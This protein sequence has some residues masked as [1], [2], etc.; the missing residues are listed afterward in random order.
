MEKSNAKKST[1]PALS[2]MQ[3]T[4]IGVMT[5]V[6]CILAPLVIPLPISPVPISFTNLAVYISLYVLGMKAGTISYL[7]YLL[8]GLVGVPVFSG[9][10]G[11]PGKLAGP[12]GGYLVGFLFMALIA[13][14]F[15]DRFSRNYILQ[16][17]GMILGTAVCYLFGT[18][19]LC[20]QM[21]LSFPAGLMAGVVPYLPGDAA[22]I[23]LTALVGP[24][25]KR[26]VSRLK[27][28]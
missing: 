18:V 23:V 9:F 8:I 3:M 21:K 17:L 24:V 28:R 7:V 11:G 16:V 2:I 15:I 6:T 12:T 5:A 10:T 20:I 13:G 14:Y 25:L 4:L 1:K 22:K 27:G 26:A 19:W